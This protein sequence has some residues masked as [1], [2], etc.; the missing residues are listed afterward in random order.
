VPHI[1]SKEILRCD[2][3]S[4]KGSILILLV[5]LHEQLLPHSPSA[6]KELLFLPFIYSHD[7]MKSL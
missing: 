4:Y 2:V 1:I 5:I 3:T 7:G 6:T